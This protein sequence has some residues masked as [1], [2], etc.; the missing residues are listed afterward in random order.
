MFNPGER[1]ISANGNPGTVQGNM[2]ADG[3]IIAIRLDSGR[4][5]G[6][7]ASKVSKIVDMATLSEVL[8]KVDVF[9][10]GLSYQETAREIFKAL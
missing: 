7:L 8:A 1:V 2:T 5:I 10:P 4:N 6:C 9:L 3:T